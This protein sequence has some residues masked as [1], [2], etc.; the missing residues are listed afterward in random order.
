[1]KK[2]ILFF[3]LILL[4]TSCGDKSIDINKEDKELLEEEVST[5]THIATSSASGMDDYVGTYYYDYEDDTPDLIEDQYIVI[6]NVNGQIIGRYYGTSDDFDEARE[7]YYPGFFVA[8][9]INFKINNKEISF[10]ISLTENDMY[11]KPVYL[12][13][14]DTK[15]VLLSGN[16]LWINKQ[17]I[18][19]SDKNPRKY[20]GKIVNNEEIILKIDNDQRIF[21]RFEGKTPDTTSISTNGEIDR[22]SQ[23]IMEFEK[24]MPI[25]DAFEKSDLSIERFEEDLK[26]TINV[27]GEIDLN[28]D[29][30]KDRINCNL[31]N[32]SDNTIS[33]NGYK[34]NLFINDIRS[35]TDFQIVDLDISD[36]YKEIVIMESG[37][38][39][40]YYPTFIRFDGNKLIKLGN[41][42]GDLFVD[43]SGKL[44]SS[45]NLYKEV[46]PVICSGYYTLVGNEFQFNKVDSDTIK[47]KQYTFVNDE[48][49]AF[50]ETTNLPEKDKAVYVDTFKASDFKAGDSFSL[51]AIGFFPDT[52][53]ILWLNITLNDNKKGNLYLVLQP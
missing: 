19:S 50:D 46:N 51:N 20:K 38:D 18:N 36:S 6:E 39:G 4:L 49:I 13:Y 26:Y 45:F 23:N 8:N 2:V 24:F 47:N 35:A 21:K 44:I 16:P 31:H 30:E 33:V 11:S 9:M 37:I 41:L 42:P 34:I 28:N 10:E 52:D 48:S 12:K 25:L 15:E 53:N 32:N 7:G 40:E 5:N 17:I 14:K 1:M 43:K 29:G 3:T 22:K 27:K